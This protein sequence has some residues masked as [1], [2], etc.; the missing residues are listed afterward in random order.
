MKASEAEALRAA[1]RHI[2]SYFDRG[3]MVAAMKRIVSESEVV[4]W[5]SPR[6]EKFVDPA[7]PVL[8]LTVDLEKARE[9]YGENPPPPPPLMP[10]ED[11]SPG[12]PHEEAARWMSSVAHGEVAAPFADWIGKTLE[13]SDEMMAAATAALPEGVPPSLLAKFVAFSIF[14]ARSNLSTMRS[15]QVEYV[16]V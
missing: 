2:M 13:E 8:S 4:S 6:A 14:S 15:M 1:R 11:A 12:G 7:R 3:E 9:A 16:D 10:G 5:A